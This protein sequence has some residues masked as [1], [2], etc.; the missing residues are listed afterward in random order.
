[1]IMGC[2]GIGVSRV[3]AAC[4]EQCN[5]AD[6]IVFP[7]ALAPYQALVLNLDPKKEDTSAKADEI[8]AILEN[9]GLDV[10][11]DDR[12][13]RPGVKFKDADLLGLPFQLVI[14]G[15]GLA[16]GIVEAKDR[17]TGVK[18]ELPIE[19]FTEAFRTW[20]QDVLRGWGY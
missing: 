20:R 10:L 16:R 12:E 4:I 3:V 15:K 17:R 8:C 9:E 14:G 5:D 7:P 18:T 19:G 1:M 13:E 11:L 2:Y 6:G